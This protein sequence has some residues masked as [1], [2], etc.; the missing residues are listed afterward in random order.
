[1]PQLLNPTR[2]EPVLRSK[3][4]HRNEK[5]THR[6]ERDMEAVKAVWQQGTEQASSW[7]TPGPWFRDKPTAPPT[8]RGLGGRDSR[9]DSASPERRL[10]S[11]ISYGAQLGCESSLGSQEVLLLL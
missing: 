1:M 11:C 5:P 6:N 8:Q 4:S 2:L 7:D 3:R 9:R 10:F